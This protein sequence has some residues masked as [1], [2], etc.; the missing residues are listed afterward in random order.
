MIDWERNRIDIP[1]EILKQ[2]A[3]V[4]VPLQ[5]ELGDVLRPIAKHNHGTIV[6]VGTVRD[7]DHANEVFTAYLKL[8]GIPRDGRGLHVLRASHA[9]L[10]IASGTPAT[11]VQTAVGWTQ[12]QTMHRYIRG[13]EDYREQVKAEAWPEDELFLRRL[14]PVQRVRASG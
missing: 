7:S 13:A 5:P 3:P 1:A 8:C 4:R 10:L 6:G 14:P 12:V 9:S 2:D 11:A